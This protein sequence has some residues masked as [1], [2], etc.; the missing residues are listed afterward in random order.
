MLR[1]CNCFN[2]HTDQLSISTIPPRL[3]VGE[4]DTVQL[5]A[6]ASGININ[7]FVY[8]WRKRGSNSLP[9]KVSHINGI[10][11]TILNAQDSDEGKYFC[12]VTNEWGSSMKSNNVI[13]TVRGMYMWQSSLYL[14]KINTLIS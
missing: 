1:I 8:Q 4:G 2:L 14:C 13:L 12:I 3:T 6:T 9:D 7:N 5:N 10:V 11:L